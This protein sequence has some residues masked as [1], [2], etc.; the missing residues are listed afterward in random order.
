MSTEPKVL[1]SLFDGTGS[2]CAPF[3]RA[4]W[5]VRRLDVDGSHGADIVS[6]IFDW[7]PASQWSGPVPDVIFA[8]PP[9][10]QYSSARTRAKHARNLVL[11]DSLVNKML[12]IID[13][14]HNRNPNLQFFV[15]NP[16]S[17][18]LWKRWVSH[19]LYHDLERHPVNSVRRLLRGR[20]RP[21]SKKRLG[22]KAFKFACGDKHVV[23]LDY[24]RYKTP[25]RKRTRF[26]TNN[27]F[28]GLL[29]NP[30]ICP[31]VVNGHHVEVAQRGPRGKLKRKDS[32]DTHAYHTIDQLH[33]YP[34]ELVAVIFEHVQS[35]PSRARTGLHAAQD[36]PPMA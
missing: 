28:E 26:M 8:G 17:S 3:A 1:L 31:G 6:D 25:Y 29:C 4:G 9:C 36:E 10:E 30:A 11:A 13:H 5:T 23:R 34:P 16:D 22:Y 2:V 12:A 33:A 14:F 27:P 18:M 21:M 24:C 32:D 20:S 15:E 35:S 7:D 19:R